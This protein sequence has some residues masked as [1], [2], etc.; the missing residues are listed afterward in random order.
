MDLSRFAEVEGRIDAAAGRAGRNR[1]DVTLIAVSKSQPIEAISA[2]YEAGHRD[3]GENRAAEMAEKAA[4]LPGDIRWHF[5]GVL[6]SNKTRLV[7][8]ITTLLHSMDRASLAKS[9]LKGSG[10]A[11]PVLIQV[12]VGDEDQKGGVPPEGVPALLEV[13]TTMGLDVQ[14]LMTIPPQTDDPDQGRSYFRSLRTV[15]DSLAG[16]G[17][18]ELALSM[19]MTDDF[20]IAIEEG[21]SMIRVGRAIFGPRLI[22]D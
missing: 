18:S 22:Q 9:W 19:G 3:F 16:P 21:A 6:Q 17:A 8:G 4:Q 7:R 10:V 5:V 11:P 1:S 12:D 20:E 15:R 14:G 2:L 13:L